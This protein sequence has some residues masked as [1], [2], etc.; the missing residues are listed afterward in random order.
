MTG[1]QFRGIRRFNGISQEDICNSS[2]FNHRSSI[3]RLEQMLFIPQDFVRILSKLTG[4]D[5]YDQ[6]VVDQYFMQLPSKYRDYDP[7]RIDAN[8]IEN[9]TFLDL[10]GNEI[11]KEKLFD[12]KKK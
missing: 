8:L 9:T 11:D 3:R 2:R 10:D 12:F 5:F 4:I 1:H 7:S 6:R